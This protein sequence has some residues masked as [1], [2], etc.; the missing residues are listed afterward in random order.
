MK[1]EIHKVTS[2]TVVGPYVLRLGF[3]DSTAQTIDYP[4]CHSLQVLSCTTFLQSV[5]NSS[6]FR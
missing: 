5:R 6:G 2:F 3:A 1:H 4:R